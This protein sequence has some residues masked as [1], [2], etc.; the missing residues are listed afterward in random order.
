M[1]YV[2]CYPDEV[3][4]K[5]LGFS[6][7][8]IIHEGNKFEVCKRLKKKNNS[9]GVI[10]FDF[11]KTDPLYLR[12]FVRVESNN[13]VTV[14][15]EKKSGNRIIVLS[16]DLEDWVIRLCKKYQIDLDKHGLSTTRDAL[17]KEIN[18]KLE[19]FGALLD[20]LLVIK[21]AELTHLRNCFK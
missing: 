10:D 17:H 1:I 6:R 3:L 2:E 9:T 20:Q 4:L 5:K 21:A 13:H 18:S 19:K 15:F 12:Q 8:E 11:G 14:Y 7:K 16:N